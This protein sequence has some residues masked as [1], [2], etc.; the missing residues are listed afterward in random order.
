MQCDDPFD[1]IVY[2]R[3][4]FENEV[5]AMRGMVLSVLGGLVLSGCV[6]TPPQLRGDFVS[7]DP[8]RASLGEFA[9]AKVRWAGIVVGERLANSDNCLEVAAFP[10]D[11]NT[12][13]PYENGLL[14]HQGFKALF[15][16]GRFLINRTQ[17]RVPP[18]FLACAARSFDRETYP[19]FSVVTLVGTLATPR[20]FQVALADCGLSRKP[21]PVAT[22]H[23]TP[24][25]S[26]SA[27]VFY[28]G[29]V[30]AANDQACVV[31]MAVVDIHEIV[32]WT[33]PPHI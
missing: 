33:E 16:D 11:S 30:H 22:V 1:A 24:M 17:Q 8:A 19:D 13:K 20:V 21:S 29:N 2:I 10:I 12:L 26:P 6:A 5:V 32:A 4:F 28:A 15:A 3:V 9:G 14:P 23:S 31:S 18:R 27:E 7:A 25:A